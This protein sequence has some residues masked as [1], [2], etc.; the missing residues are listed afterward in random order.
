MQIADAIAN[1]A[2]ASAAIASAAIANAA[3]APEPNPHLLPVRQKNQQAVKIQGLCGNG[4]QQ[5]AKQ[6]IIGGLSDKQGKPIDKNP[7]FQPSVKSVTQITKK[8]WWLSYC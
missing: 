8:Y 7:I 2:I 3:I 4:M 1:A 5:K 6:T